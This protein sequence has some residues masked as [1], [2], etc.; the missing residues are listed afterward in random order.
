MRLLCWYLSHGPGMGM[1]NESRVQTGL[2]VV[3]NG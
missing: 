2:G 3:G 1:G